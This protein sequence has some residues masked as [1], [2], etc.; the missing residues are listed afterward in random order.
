MTYNHG[1]IFIFTLNMSIIERSTYEELNVAAEEGNISHLYAVIEKDPFALE[2]IDQRPFIAT[3]L[4]VAASFGRVQFAA[5][6]MRL[7]PSFALK[8]NQQGWCPIHLA[9][10]RDQ[11][12]MV[13][14]FI[15]INKDLIRLKGREGFT[16]LHLVSQMGDLNLLN[17]FL[18]A[19]PNSIEDVTVRN[20]TALHIAVKNHQNYSLKFLV[21][22][23]KT[24]WYIGAEPS[25]YTILNWK[26]E[27]DNTI[28][29]ISTSYND[30]EAIRVL[31]KRKILVDLKAKNSEGL[32]ALEIAGTEETRRMLEKAN[33]DDQNIMFKLFK[34]IYR[35]AET[36]QSILFNVP[37]EDRETYLIVVTLIATAT[38]QA[39][40]SPPGGLYQPDTGN[41][42]SLSHLNVGSILNSTAI[43]TKSSVGVGGNSVMST[44]DFIIFSL[45]NMLSFILSSF[46][47]FGLIPSGSFLVVLVGLPL[48]FLQLNYIYSMLVIS[49]TPFA[50]TSVCII[51]IVLYIT[52]LLE[53]PVF[54]AKVPGRGL[55]LMD[56][57]ATKNVDRIHRV[58]T[59]SF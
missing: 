45:T 29:H 6:I 18:K 46:T 14:C 58:K 8:P 26:D 49:P 36:I 30:R 17:D 1:T 28:L 56:R 9:L 3:P 25:E 35:L 39:S 48:W 22:W 33:E 37:S 21:R 41:Q 31:A 13:H 51:L 34:F 4:H 44:L 42:N 11:K 53:I 27:E 16:P 20:E 7:K 43:N 38:Y 10:Q 47:I 32:T 5:E 40:L 55:L 2:N 50:T 19:C 52:M 23:L 57:S 59:F 15:T 24:Y 12:R 54:F